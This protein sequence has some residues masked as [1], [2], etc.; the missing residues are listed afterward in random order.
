MSLMRYWIIFPMQAFGGLT[1]K[2]SK[3]RS[4]LSGKSEDFLVD[5]FSPLEM[6]INLASFTLGVLSRTGPLLPEP[7]DLLTGLRGCKESS[8]RMI[9][10]TVIV[11]VVLSRDKVKLHRAAD[12]SLTESLFASRRMRSPKLS[13]DNPSSFEHRIPVSNERIVGGR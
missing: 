2:E 10:S 5:H 9:R 12:R 6:T 7:I 11:V 8:E 13:S 1:D 4:S 3:F